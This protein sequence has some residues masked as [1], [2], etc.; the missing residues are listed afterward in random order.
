MKYPLYNLDDESFEDLVAI[1]CEDILGM[2]T[3]VFS[4]GKD[5]GRD[6]K[7]TGTANKIPSTSDPWSGKFIIQ[8]KHTC[9][10]TASCSD[11]EFQRILGKELPKIK[12]LKEQGKIDFYLIFS[13]R[14]LT[15]LQDPKIEDLIDE[16][17]GVQNIV[18]GKETIDLWLETQ[19]QIARKANLNRLLMPLQFYE[20]DLRDLVVAFANAKI[21]KSRITEIEDEFCGMPIEEK[22]KLNKLSEEYF[23]GV[24]KNSVDDFARIR[25]FLQD[26]KNATFLTMYQNTISDIQEEITIRRTEYH[27]F[28]EIL[29]HLYKVVLD[30]SNYLLKNNRRMIRVFLH[31]MYFHCDIGIKEVQSA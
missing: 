20:E 3:I 7:F 23:N 27:A 21:S 25:A 4:K 8:A 17:V 30:T 15:G 22:N 28:D 1:L 14:K 19:P 24:F 5:G 13:N 16:Y 9:N 6:A 12:A 18:Y 31:Y 26:P 10:P 11:A 29:N 2:G